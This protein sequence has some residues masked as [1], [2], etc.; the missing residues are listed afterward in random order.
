MTSLTEVYIDPRQGPPERRTSLRDYSLQLPCLSSGTKT[1]IGTPIFT[2]SRRGKR[3]EVR[4][5]VVDSVFIQDHRM[6]H[7]IGLGSKDLPD[8]GNIQY[9]KSLVPTVY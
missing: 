5:V 4:G 7:H 6:D 2:K 8:L 1:S 9:G 3:N